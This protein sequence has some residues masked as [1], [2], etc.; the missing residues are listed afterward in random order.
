MW[1][2]WFA[3]YLDAD[4][5]LPDPRLDFHSFRHTFKAF[6]QLSGIDG[7]VIE[8]LLGHAPDDWYGRNDGTEKRLPFE[9]LVQAVEKLDFPGLQLG[10]LVHRP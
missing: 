3:E 6:A 2:T 5:G 1:S 10:H 8:E 9:L 4:V 7:A